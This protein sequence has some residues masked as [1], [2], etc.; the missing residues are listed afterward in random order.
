VKS[1]KNKAPT[2]LLHIAV[3]EKANIPRL[4]YRTNVPAIYGRAF[5]GGNPAVFRNATP[6]T[7]AVNGGKHGAIAAGGGKKREVRLGR[8]LHLR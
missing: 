6:A 7:Y 4:E 5:M 1:F 2:L 3:V 8:S